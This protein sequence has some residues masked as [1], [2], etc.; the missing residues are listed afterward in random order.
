MQN[1]LCAG[2][3]NTPAP[4]HWQSH[5]LLCNSG[6]QML[7][8]VWTTVLSVGT[9]N[10]STLTEATSV[11]ATQGSWRM[12]WEC[13]QVRYILTSLDEVY[14]IHM[15]QLTRVRRC[16]TGL[17]GVNKKWWCR[18]ER[19]TMTKCRLC[20]LS[21]PTLQFRGNYWARYGTRQF[22]TRSQMS[23]RE[24]ATSLTQS[25]VRRIWSSYDSL[26]SPKSFVLKSPLQNCSKS[27][28]GKTSAF[29]FVFKRKCATHLPLAVSLDRWVLRRSA[30]LSCSHR[31]MKRI[32]ANR[33]SSYVIFARL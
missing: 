19:G 29:A 10:V 30:H 3:I 31:K 20:S 1:G 26:A 21:G 9:W 33:P 16:E 24:R 11:T 6:S 25:S 8:N 7:M 14:P 12:T 27:L 4:P 28:L 5:L 13:A 17:Q 2:K 23:W 18:G 15:F 22:L 32:A